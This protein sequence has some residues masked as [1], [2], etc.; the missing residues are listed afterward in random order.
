MRYANGVYTLVRIVTSRSLPVLLHLFN[1][2]VA[3]REDVIAV[4]RTQAVGGVKTLGAC[5][6]EAVLQIIAYGNV[7]LLHGV[8]SDLER[9]CAETVGLAGEGHVSAVNIRR[10]RFGRFVDD[11][12][13]CAALTRADVKLFRLQTRALRNRTRSFSSGNNRMI[14][15][16]VSGQQSLTH[17]DEVACAV[18]ACGR[19]PRPAR[20]TEGPA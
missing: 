8:R 4:I 7:E 5:K 17:P 19:M 20:R 3:F 1:L 13:F 11:G 16:P 15:Q 10:E 2:R 14:V 6:E 12:H 9:L 18:R